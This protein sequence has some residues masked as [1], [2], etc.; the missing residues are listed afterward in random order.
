MKEKEEEAGIRQ[1]KKNTEDLILKKSRN[2]IS[3]EIWR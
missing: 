1:R 3:E 2:N